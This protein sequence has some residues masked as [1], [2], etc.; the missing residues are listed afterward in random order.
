MTIQRRSI[1]RCLVAATL[2]CWAVAMTPP[3]AADSGGGAVGLPGGAS[4]LRRPSVL[5]AVPYMGWNTYY[6]VGGI[7]DEATIISVAHALID[8]GLAQA[9]YR[10]VWL[11]FGWASGQRDIRGELVVDRHRWP[12]G[13]SWLTAWLHRRGLLAGIYTDAGASGCYGQG[14]PGFS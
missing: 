9:G 5:A 12:H 6:G 3:A 2:A 14:D 4:G 10:I 13:L 11:D 7:F 1:A 8:R